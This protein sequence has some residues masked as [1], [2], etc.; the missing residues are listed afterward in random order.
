MKTMKKLAYLLG[1]MMVLS[2][3]FTSCEKDGDDDDPIVPTLNQPAAWFGTWHATEVDDNGTLV[4]AQNYAYE[5]GKNLVKL[6]WKYNTPQE[7]VATYTSWEIVGDDLVVVNNH[8]EKH[9]YPIWEHPTNGEIQV[10]FSHNQITTLV[11][12]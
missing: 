6:Y 8:N 11:K 3:G 12:Q 1:L 10:E 7:N 9:T 5:F 2:I 4:V